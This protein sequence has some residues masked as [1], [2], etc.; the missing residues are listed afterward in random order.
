MNKIANLIKA[1]RLCDMGA[2][3][4]LLQPV[5]FCQSQWAVMKQVGDINLINSLLG[6]RWLI[7][8]VILATTVH[9]PVV[10]T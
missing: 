2:E 3:V 7:I 8:C 4:S 9:S 5:L 6:N 10:F 1:T